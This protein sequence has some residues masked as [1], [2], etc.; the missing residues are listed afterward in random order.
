M[1]G[2]L[3]EMAYQD[4]SDSDRMGGIM[5]WYIRLSAIAI[6]LRVTKAHLADG[7]KMT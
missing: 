5:K 6:K 3:S 1:G 2:D 4:L 7:S